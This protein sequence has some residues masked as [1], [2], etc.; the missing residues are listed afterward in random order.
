LQSVPYW[1][2]QAVKVGRAH[3]TPARQ[4]DRSDLGEMVKAFQGLARYVIEPVDP[5]ARTQRRYT[6]EG[7]RRDVTPELLAKLE[8]TELHLNRSLSERSRTGKNLAPSR[9]WLGTQG[10]A[11]QRLRSDL[12]KELED[13]TA[14]LT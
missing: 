11:F 3:I 4:P 9:L 14:S 12:A 13:L 7:T 8:A 6:A 1:L 10:Q 5:R 2:E